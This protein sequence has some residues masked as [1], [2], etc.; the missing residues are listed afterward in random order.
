LADH[1]AARTLLAG[2]SLVM[3]AGSALLALAPAAAWVLAA[4]FVLGL[5]SS[6]TNTTGM[7]YFSTGVALQRRGTS[8]AVFSA[9]LLGGQAL[10]PTVGGVLA[11]AGGWRT[12]TGIGALIGAVVGIVLLRARLGDQP[13]GTQPVHPGDASPPPPIGLP[14]KAVLYAV[15]FVSFATLGSLPQTLVPIIG[16][17]FGL[18]ATTIGLALGIGGAC[19]FVGAFVGGVVSDRVGRKAALVPGLAVQALGVALLAVEG[20]IVAWMAA[21]VLL[22]LA[23]YGIS[24]AAAMLV[25]VGSGTGAGRR[26]GTFRFVGDSGLIA[27]PALSAGLYESTGTA[28]AVLPIAAL[29]IVVALGSAFLLPETRQHEPLSDGA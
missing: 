24:V 14:A 22:S 12:V 29:L 3:A 25:D 2:C 6:L 5:A 20:N 13:A 15:P 10:G 9:A 17:G 26:L 8:L 18:S 28:A 19:R 27:G 23:S 1:V 21:I 4:A 11:L 7:T 16:A